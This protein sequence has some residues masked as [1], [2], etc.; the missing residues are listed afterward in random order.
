MESSN[1]SVNN[2]SDDYKAKELSEEKSGQMKEVSGS[3]LD[4]SESSSSKSDPTSLSKVD[5][6]LR[7][8]FSLSI[9]NNK[10]FKSKE[11]QNSQME[12]LNE[13]TSKKLLPKEL[14]VKPVVSS[15]GKSFLGNI[16]ETLLKSICFQDKLM[17][18]SDNG[19]TAGKYTATVEL[20]DRGGREQLY[21]RA[22]MKGRT[23]GLS[24]FTSLNAYLSAKNLSVINQYY[25]EMTNFGNQNEEKIVD[26]KCDP[27]SQKLKVKVLIKARNTRKRLSYTLKN[28]D[29]IGLVTEA[30]NIA[31]LRMFV[32]MG[33]PSEE[34]SFVSLDHECGQLV[35]SCY[36]RL[37]SIDQTVGKEKIKVHGIERK[38]MLKKDLPQNWQSYF[39]KEGFLS[40][41]I[42]TGSSVKMI[43]KKIP[44]S[45][46]KEFVADPKP[47]FNKKA[48]IWR[49]DL[50]LLS[51]CDDRKKNLK[52]DHHRYLDSHPEVSALIQDFLFALVFQKPRNVFQFTKS[53]F[54]LN[55]CPEVKDNEPVRKITEATPK[56]TQKV[57]FTV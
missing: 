46:S 25:H 8:M 2:K 24:I 33:C 4:E 5:I 35:P 26:M 41:R 10:I 21:V 16:D 27:D 6:A 36:K 53:Y 28:A 51:R 32:K 15:R 31:L 50:M 47:V 30:S 18:T 34:I 57:R 11:I 22:V 20:V 39:T 44:I 13:R 19:K 45:P 17:L 9:E 48:L 42:Q 56:S 38:L 37:P 54:T 49:R 40:F 14:E 55:V 43:L 23:D 7:N 52:A 12:V 1:A 29:D 3:E